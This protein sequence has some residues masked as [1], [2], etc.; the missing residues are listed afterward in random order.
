MVSMAA[1]P[2]QLD[3]TIRVVTP[4]NIAFRYQAAGPFRRLPAFL[5]DLALRWAVM[6]VLVIVLLF[7]GAIL[8]GPFALVIGILAYFL[9]DWFYGGLFETFWNG[10]TPGKRL[11]GIR[12]LTIEGQPINAAQAI[13][14]NLL[15][16]AD[17]MPIVSLAP[18][19][20]EEG[21][22]IFVPTCAVAV[23]VAMFNRR[24]QRLGDLVCGTMVIVEERG[25]LRGVTR[26]EDPRVQQLSEILPLGF[27]VSRTMAQAL[28]A[29]VE[30]RRH[31]GPAR[32]REIAKHLAAPLLVR[33]GLP[34][35]TNYDLMLCALY[36]RTF[37]ADDVDDDYRPPSLGN[38][39]GS[40]ALVASLSPPVIAP[41]PNFSIETGPLSQRL[42]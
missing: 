7:G 22:P 13:L 41:E 8:L 33:F 2:E 14:R 5:I 19:L 27:E 37:I 26:V 20:G 30:R 11:L 9:L 10:Q 31:F 35:D 32:Q 12:V 3:S 39:A 24:Y 25:W 23:G 36:Y 15:R 6:F 29:Y 4:E 18:L 28:S 34:A 40:P 21:M 17:M 1:Q 42:H 16:Y 38:D